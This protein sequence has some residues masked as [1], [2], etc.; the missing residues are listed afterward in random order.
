MQTLAVI[1]C[2][3]AARDA[4]TSCHAGVSKRHQELGTIPRNLPGPV[5]EWRG[6]GRVSILVVPCGSS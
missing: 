1:K 4:W 6:A 2:P 3:L 5:L